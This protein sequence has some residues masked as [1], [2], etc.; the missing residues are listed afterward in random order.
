MHVKY[1][2]FS[3]CHADHAGGFEYIYG[4]T[5]CKM[6]ASKVERGFLEIQSLILVFIWW[7]SS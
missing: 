4:K 3:H 2:V 6:I 5:H 7:I 1:L